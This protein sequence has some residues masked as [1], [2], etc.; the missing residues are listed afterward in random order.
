VIDFIDYLFFD[1]RIGDYM[2]GDGMRCV[3]LTNGKHFQLTFRGRGGCCEGYRYA[4]QA[5][6]RLGSA[7]VWH[8]HNS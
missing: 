5:C 3:L 6:T 7:V 8:L 4:Y 1:K 2:H